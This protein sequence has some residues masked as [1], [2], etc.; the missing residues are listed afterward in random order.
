MLLVTVCNR[1]ATVNITG[2]LLSAAVLGQATCAAA[3]GG[4]TA[5]AVP[6]RESSEHSCD[7]VYRMGRLVGPTGAGGSW[8]C[9]IKAG[10]SCGAAS[11]Y[12]GCT[13]MGGG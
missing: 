8:G 4:R 11:M 12:V 2:G 6:E 7:V 9:G 13:S 10:M 1:L 3:G 5:A